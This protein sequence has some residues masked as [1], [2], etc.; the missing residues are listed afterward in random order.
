MLR[1]HELAPSPNNLKVR[2]ALVFKQIPF[3][4]TPIDPTDRS[5]LVE[6]SGQELSPVIEDRG[7]V[8]HDSEAILHYLDANYPQTPKLYPPAR[9][10]RKA[11]DA[12]KESIDRK[13]ARPWFPVF[14][15]G[16]GLREEFDERAP[17]RFRQ[18]LSWL[19][20]QLGERD[21]FGGEQQAPIMDLRAAV[22]ACYAFPPPGL[23][24]R[25]PAMKKVQQLLAADPAQ[26]PRLVEALAPWFERLG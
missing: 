9:N 7:I 14:F 5:N 18:A 16:L 4:A 25:S 8:L 19:E 17:L 11:C 20:E 10:E 21:S 2:A 13:M 6:I 22:W 23:T 3:E 24:A 12:F 15:Y 26:T 1:F